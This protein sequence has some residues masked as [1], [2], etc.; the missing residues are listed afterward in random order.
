MTDEESEMLIASV[1]VILCLKVLIKINHYKL[2]QNL[3]LKT[4]IIL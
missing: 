1:L 4:M 3:G 2:F